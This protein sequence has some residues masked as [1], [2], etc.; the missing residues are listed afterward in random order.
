MKKYKRRNFGERKPSTMI[1]DDVNIEKMIF[2]TFMKHV[3]DNN[4]YTA[5]R[6]S[7]N[8]DNRDRDLIHV[9]S[10]N[11]CNT[12]YRHSLNRIGHIGCAFVSAKSIKDILNIL[13]MHRRGQKVENSKEFQMMLM[14]MVNILIHS[15]IEHAVSHNMQV[16][17]K[18]GN[19][20]FKEVGIALFGD[21]FKD[22]TEDMIDPRQREFIEAM[23]NFNGNRDGLPREAVEEFMRRMQRNRLGEDRFESPFNN[24]ARPPIYNW[25]DIA[26]YLDDNY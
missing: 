11:L 9:L 10:S 23:Q 24:V 7:V 15:C 8:H 12:A 6:W 26:Y 1:A 4:L 17:E 16:L 22:M 19:T 20:V 25:E 21:D 13:H 2:R 5:F 3:K 18:I 14:N